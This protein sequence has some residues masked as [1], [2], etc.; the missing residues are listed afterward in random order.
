M[1]KISIE[2]QKKTFQRVPEGLMEIGGETLGTL[3][4]EIPEHQIAEALPKVAQEVGK[5]NTQEIEKA[6]ID[7]MADGELVEIVQKII[8]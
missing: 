3:T 2:T 1:V 8:K 4:T 6:N 5:F 7:D